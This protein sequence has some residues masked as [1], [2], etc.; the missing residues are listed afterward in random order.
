M[1]GTRAFGARRFFPMGIHRREAEYHG[2]ARFRERHPT[3]LG[4]GESQ[5]VN[6]SFL[7]RCRQSGEADVRPPRHRPQGFSKL[8]WFAHRFPAATMT[9]QPSRWRPK[10]PRASDRRLRGLPSTVGYSRGGRGKT[11]PRRRVLLAS[12]IRP[13]SAGAPVAA[14]FPRPAAGH[15]QLPGWEPESSSWS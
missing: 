1:R 15:W 10:C 4:F 12:T 3:E 7:R 6:A 11:A 9:R 14:G 2:C 5:F 8:G 13:V